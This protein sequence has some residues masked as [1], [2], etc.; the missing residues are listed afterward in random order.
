MMVRA[1]LCVGITSACAEQTWGNRPHPN[2]GWDHLRVC[3]ADLLD[4]FNI[5]A[6]QGSPPR[7]R[8]RPLK[9]GR[10]YD[11]HGITSACA[12]QTSVSKARLPLTRDH[13]R[14]CGADYPSDGYDSVYE[15]SPPRVRSRPK[16]DDTPHRKERITSACAE[17]TPWVRGG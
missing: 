14:V 7:V 11:V 8:S 17:Q 3:G 12:E 16:N 13:L 10:E 2:D 4:G 15:G 5:D 9:V 1:S 6:V